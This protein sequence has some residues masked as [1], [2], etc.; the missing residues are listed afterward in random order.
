MP[1]IT[2]DRIGERFYQSGVSKGVLYLP[3]GSVIPWNGITSITEKPKR[4]VSSVYYDGSKINDLATLSEF[5][6]TLKALTY[7]EEFSDLESGGELR[8]GFYVGDRPP[9]V[10]GISY[11]TNIGSDLDENLGYRIHLVYNVTAIPADRTFDTIGDNV[12]PVEFQWDITAIPEELTGVRPTA[13]VIIDSRKVDDWLLQDI[14]DRIYG[15]NETDPSLPPLQE[16]HDLIMNW[17]RFL[18]EEEDGIIE[19]TCSRPEGIINLPTEETKLVG[20]NHII[21]DS[22]ELEL[23]NTYD[24]NV[25]GRLYI[26]VNSDGSWTATTESMTAIELDPETQ[27]FVIHSPAA[28]FL[29]EDTYVLEDSWVI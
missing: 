18:V 17:F 10:F 24:E 15:T 2:W 13:S 9:Q 1:V 14:E 28:I 19:I 11:V 21:H 25:A 7:P 12:E 26:T 20:I 27:E 23:F 6:A 22:G 16:L 29:D 5:Q 8:P 4:G 3:N